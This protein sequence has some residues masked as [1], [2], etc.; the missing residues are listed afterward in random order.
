MFFF[1]GTLLDISP[2][3][4]APAKEPKNYEIIFLNFDF[5]KIDII[6]NIE[7]PAPTL[8]TTFDANAGQV[9]YFLLNELYKMAP[10]LPLV[11]IKSLILIILV[12]FFTS[13]FN[14]SFLS[15]SSCLN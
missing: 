3:D 5:I 8:S 11:I 7:S 15:L 1:I 12:N 13:I 9:K 10:L 6:D 4:S 2:T 14:F